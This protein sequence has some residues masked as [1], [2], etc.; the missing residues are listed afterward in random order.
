MARR[1]RIDRGGIAYHVLNRRV[2]RLPLLEK[3]EEYAAFEKVLDQAGG[4][5]RPDVGSRLR[6]VGEASPDALLPDAHPLAS[7][8]LS[9]P[10][11]PAPGSTS[12]QL[13]DSGRRHRGSE[14]DGAG[15]WRFRL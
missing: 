11:R 12:P 3:D 6:L 15:R 14:V 5:R 2:G 9:G 4:P 10:R 1:L 7:G 13:S 8:A